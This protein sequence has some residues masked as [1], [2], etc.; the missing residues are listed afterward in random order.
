MK[1]AGDILMAVVLVAAL[2][3]MVRPKSQ[4]PSLI[5][6]FTNGFGSILKAATGGGSWSG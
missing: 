1:Q 6:A 2:F 5:S 3:V 4:G